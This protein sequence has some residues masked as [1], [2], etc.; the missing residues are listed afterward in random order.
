MNLY[1]FIFFCNILIVYTYT[2]VRA[3][4]RNPHLNF[5]NI[6]YA[7]G[8][9]NITLNRYG[10]SRILTV[11]SQSSYFFLQINGTN[12]STTLEFYNATYQITP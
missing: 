12:R 10:V 9:Y 2:Y 3:F 6:L 1:R 4:Y 8:K 7:F 11:S 5:Q